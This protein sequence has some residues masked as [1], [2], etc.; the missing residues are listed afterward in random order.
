[1]HRRLARPHPRQREK[2]ATPPQFIREWYPEERLAAEGAARRCRALMRARVWRQR[3]ETT[4][5]M[6]RASGELDEGA[7]LIEEGRYTAKSE[8]QR[9]VGDHAGYFRMPLEDGGPACWSQ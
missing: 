4:N 1:V 3:R 6:R 9:Q 7:E 8:Q 5:L 2:G